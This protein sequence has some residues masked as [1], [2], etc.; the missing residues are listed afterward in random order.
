MSYSLHQQNQKN[1]LPSIPMTI[2]VTSLRTSDSLAI[3]TFWTRPERSSIHDCCM[4]QSI[5][6]DHNL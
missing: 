4:V 6:K 5:I 3:R 1:D 2:T